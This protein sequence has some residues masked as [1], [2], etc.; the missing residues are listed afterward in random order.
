MVAR[1]KGYDYG[2]VHEAC[3]ERGVLPIIA[4]RRFAHES[5]WSEV[6]E[7]EHGGWTFAGAHFKRKRTKWRCPSGDCKPASRWV[8]ADRR[9]PLVPRGSKRFGQLT[10]GVQP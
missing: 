3:H 5:N 6:P 1:R 8:K 2:P 7:C 4:R 9:H 10:R